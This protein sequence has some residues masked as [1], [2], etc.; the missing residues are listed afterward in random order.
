MA[1][2]GVAFISF[3]LEAR[4]T[5]CIDLTIIAFFVE[6]KPHGLSCWDR[7]NMGIRSRPVLC[8]DCGTGKGERGRGLEPRKRSW[9]VEE[10]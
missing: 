1:F 9:D 3:F 2:L 10:S 6:A 5:G 7:K 8:F 4:A